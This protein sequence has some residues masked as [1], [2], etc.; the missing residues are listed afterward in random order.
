MRVAVYIHTKKTRG[1][2]DNII[3]NTASYLTL[4][5]TLWCLRSYV[6]YARTYESRA[7]LEQ[8]LLKSHVI[9][10]YD[11]V[12]HDANFASDVCNTRQKIIYNTR[13]RIC[14]TYGNGRATNIN[15]VAKLKMFTVYYG[16]YEGHEHGSRVPCD[17]LHVSTSLPLTG[18]SYGYCLGT[19]LHAT[20]SPSPPTIVSIETP[21]RS[22][23]SPPWIKSPF[24]SPLLSWLW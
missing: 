14:K 15:N 17:W 2:N 23:L 11:R 18:C 1:H 13:E 9:A 5:L 21:Y 19:A 12:W 8:F 7:K 24:I 20:I 16:W 10:R 4:H 3:L 6:L 22:I